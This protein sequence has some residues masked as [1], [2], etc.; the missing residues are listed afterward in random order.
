MQQKCVQL[1]LPTSFLLLR[2]SSS[3]RQPA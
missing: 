3:Q 1:L 2:A